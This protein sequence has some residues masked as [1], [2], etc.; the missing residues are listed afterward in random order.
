MS[1][2]EHQTDILTGLGIVGMAAGAVTAGINGPKIKEAVEQRK[3]ELGVEK[4]PF[5]ELFK[6]SWRYLIIP[7]TAVVGGAT[8]VVMAHV[9]DKKAAAGY[10]VAYAASEAALTECKD[11][12]VEVVGEKKAKEIQEEISKDHSRADPI[13]EDKVYVVAGGDHLMRFDW[14]GY[15]FRSTVQNVEA[16]VNRLNAQINCGERISV[17]D[18]CYEFGK[19]SCESD[20][21][22]IWDPMRNG[23][24]SLG[25]GGDVTNDGEPFIIWRFETRP[26]YDAYDF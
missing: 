16:V 5:K 13:E 19:E 12:I 3:K 17:S 2:K 23:L 7:T 20:E 4:L 24:I 10:A 1:I 14:N 22:Y 9:G 8:C 18:L 25:K 26:I 11:K 15:T 21:K 6:V